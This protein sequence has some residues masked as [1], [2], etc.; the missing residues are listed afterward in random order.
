MIV[1]LDIRAAAVFAFVVT[2]S[3]AMVYARTLLYLLNVLMALVYSSSRLV[4][5]AGDER[6]MEPFK[7]RAMSSLM[8]ALALQ[9][10]I[11]DDD[12][13]A[14]FFGLSITS[15]LVPSAAPSYASSPPSGHLPP[16][17]L[18]FSMTF[19]STSIFTFT[20]LLCRHPRSASL[21]PPTRSIQRN[22]HDIDPR[23]L[24]Q[25]HTLIMVVVW[26]HRIHPDRIHPELL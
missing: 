10:D 3:F 26:I 19:T 9:L 7:G 15:S 14:S 20:T 6:S 8:I 13:L 4:V 11:S 24:Q 22:S 2:T 16:C 21:P 18:P 12:Q 17:S 5:H 25:L 1:K 23:I